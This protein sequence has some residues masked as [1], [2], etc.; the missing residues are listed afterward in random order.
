MAKKAVD[1][2]YIMLVHPEGTRSSD[3]KLAKLQD[4]AS[5]ISI[6]SNVPMVPTY[7]HGGY[8]VF[9]RHMSVPKP[10]DWKKFKRKSITI[11][12]GKPLLP[13]DYNNVSEM[14]EALRQWLL[15]RQEKPLT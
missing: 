15:T 9:S 13:T 11:E 8:E 1:Q 6:K 4:G 14:T 5:Y 7:V 10:F 3:G 2:G 12:F